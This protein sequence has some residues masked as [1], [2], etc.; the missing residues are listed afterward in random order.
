MSLELSAML[1]GGIGLILLGM[2]LMTDGLR[3]AAAPALREILSRSTRTRLR[4]VASGFLVNSL[5]QSSSAI[6]VATI[7]EYIQ[8]LDRTRLPSE[9]DALPPTT[10]SDV[11]LLPGGGRAR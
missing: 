8:V 7:G 11:V 3:V 4:G 9:L 5:V 6:T 1:V 10:S 2:R